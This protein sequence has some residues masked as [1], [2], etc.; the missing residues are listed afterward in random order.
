MTRLPSNNCPITSS[1]FGWIIFLLL[2]VRADLVSASLD[3]R[4]SI[5]LDTEAE[6][7]GFCALPADEAFDLIFDNF[8]EKFERRCAPLRN[9]VD[10]ELN[11]T[12]PK[13]TCPNTLTGGLPPAKITA[14]IGNY[15]YDRRI[16]G[17]QRTRFPTDV[18]STSKIYFSLGFSVSIGPDPETLSCSTVFGLDN[19]IVEMMIKL[20]SMIREDFC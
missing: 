10:L 8:L 6:I 18:A 16:G 2:V 11:E 12:C 19:K 3:R 13:W 4:T 14:K 15:S 1:L 9:Q 5:P 20:D 17:I 7:S